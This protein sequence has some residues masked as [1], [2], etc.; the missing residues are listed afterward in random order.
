MTIENFTIKNSG[1]QKI[2]GVTIDRNLNFNEH[3]S[4]QY[5][6]NKNEITALAR[7]FPRMSFKQR[8]DLM[9]A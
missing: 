8:R 7:N 1:S 2:L 5:K 3:A 6:K 4:N 9:R